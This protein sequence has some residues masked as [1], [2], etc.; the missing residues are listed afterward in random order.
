MITN[1]LAIAVPQRAAT[2]GPALPQADPVV[3]ARPR[4]DAVGSPGQVSFAQYHRPSIGI[5]SLTTACYTSVV[6][7]LATARDTGC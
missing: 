3:R 1:D 4:V 2:A 5:F 7:G 6:V